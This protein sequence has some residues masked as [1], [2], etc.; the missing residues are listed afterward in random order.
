MSDEK[1]LIGVTGGS[2]QYLEMRIHDTQIKLSFQIDGDY[3]KAEKWVQNTQCLTG[4]EYG[5]EGDE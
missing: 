4:S 3:P 1:E 5:K 2:S